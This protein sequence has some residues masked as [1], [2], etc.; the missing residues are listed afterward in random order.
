M[1]DNPNIKN[2]I[3]PDFV[4]PELVEE[5][6][7][8]EPP[9]KFQKLTF[10]GGFS[11]VTQSGSKEAT[12]I[13]NEVVIKQEYFK[14]GLVLEGARCVMDIGANI[15]IFTLEV[16]RQSP[17]TV[18]YSFEAIPDTFQ[19]L[20]QNV[21]SLGGTGAH[22]FNVALGAQDHTQ[23]TFTYYPNMA[24]NSTAS[25]ALKAQQR[26]G[27]D[28]IFGQ[29]Q[30][31][32]FFQSETRLVEVRTLSSIIREQGITYVDYLKIDVE[33]A[34]VSV[35]EGIEEAHWPIFKQMGIETHNAALRE[36]VSKILVSHGFEVYSDLGI[37]SCFGDAMVY[38]RQP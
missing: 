20:Q 7:V 2:F 34:E 15:G 29:E 18:V 10:P 17:D 32:I 3:Q 5:V 26:Q 30:T 25:P 21:L 38:A 1:S 31:A 9:L 33:G 14:N 16:M 19:A 37:S 13:F 36:Q 11:F 27:M 23:M 24:G 22:V 8:S 35:L 6:T 12:L 4:R 28:Q